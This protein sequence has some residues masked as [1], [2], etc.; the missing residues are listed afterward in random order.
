[1]Y[2]GK[3]Y[4]A[5]SILNNPIVENYLVGV[6]VNSSGIKEKLSTSINKY[7]KELIEEVTKLNTSFYK[8]VRANKVIIKIIERYHGNIPELGNISNLIYGQSGTI[9]YN[10]LFKRALRT[11]GITHKDVYRALLSDIEKQ[12]DRL[13]RNIKISKMLL[14]ELGLAEVYKIIED[15]TSM[16]FED[17]IEYLEANN[18]IPKPSYLDE[19]AEK[20]YY[21]D[22]TNY[23]FG[24]VI[25]IIDSH[26][27]NI[28]S[29]IRE[30][31]LNNR[32]RLSKRNTEVEVDLIGR[33]KDK[34]KNDSCNIQRDITT[35]YYESLCKLNRHEA[36]ELAFKVE[37]MGTVAYYVNMVRFKGRSLSKVGYCDE[38][39]RVTYDVETMKLFK[40][41]QEAEDALTRLKN[42]YD[43]QEFMLMAQVQKL[44]GTRGKNEELDNQFYE[45]RLNMAKNLED[46]KRLYNKT[47][48][49]LA[50]LKLG[51]RIE[52]IERAIMSTEAQERL[53]EAQQRAK[54]EHPRKRKKREIIVYTL[55]NSVDAIVHKLNKLMH[56]LEDVLKKNIDQYTL[57]DM[58]DSY[59]IESFECDNQDFMKFYNQSMCIDNQIRMEL[60]KC[61]DAFLN[62]SLESYKQIGRESIF[63]ISVLENGEL[64]Y[65]SDSILSRKIC[66]RLTV[67]IASA[68]L[69]FT[70]KSAQN[71]RDEVLRSIHGKKVDKLD[72]NFEPVV[73]VTE[74]QLQGDNTNEHSKVS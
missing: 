26:K 7:N 5:G 52:E 11:Y 27:V 72:Y 37:K 69:F 22:L 67:D 23:Q 10:R 73:R 50:K 2:N 25:G 36:T 12:K 24:A 64:K 51:E 16:K 46:T 21:E 40:S 43:T 6:R 68:T 41:E 18:T 32:E 71:K 58:L 31:L 28:D 30:S 59:N 14:D 33:A 56:R 42:R 65:F 49:G 45:S 13:K 66:E 70:R 3:R 29:T 47:K 57:I 48:P 9:K 53:C 60:N 15:T 55:E 17:Y 63:I 35:S 38:D 62:D 34:L 20:K 4:K 54:I 74:I 44:L 8:L 1:M 39:F 19:E 61:N